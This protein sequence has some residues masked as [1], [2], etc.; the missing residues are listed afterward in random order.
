MRLGLA[1]GHA[2]LA[3]W[4]ALT[5]AQ[6]AFAERR[7][8]FVVGNSND[9]SVPRLSNPRNDASDTIARLKAMGFDVIPGLDLDRKAGAFRDNARL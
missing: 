3:I 8:A 2:L 6:P 1:L 5:G 9:T 7:V 4:F